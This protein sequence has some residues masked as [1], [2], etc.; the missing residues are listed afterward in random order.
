MAMPKSRIVRGAVADYH[1][2]IGSL[3]V[4]EFWF[5]RWFSVSGCAAR[6]AA[7]K[8]IWPSPRPR[9]FAKRRCRL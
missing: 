8:S 9:S 3:K 7:A 4:S 1:K 5:P 6:G 2:R